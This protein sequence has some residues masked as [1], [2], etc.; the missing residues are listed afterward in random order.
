MHN[1]SELNVGDLLEGLR[2]GRL[3]TVDPDTTLQEA[4][5]IQEAH[6][7]SALIIIE[8][9]KLFGIV[10]ERDLVR[11]AYCKG[12]NPKTAFVKEIMTPGKEVVIVT[13]ETTLK[14]AE[15]LMTKMGFRHLPVMVGEKLDAILSERDLRRAKEIIKA[16]FESRREIQ[17]KVMESTRT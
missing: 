3:I 17:E 14:E 9:K 13:K 16:T 11:K 1:D 4:M 6:D 2:Q 10:T 8:D 12:K 5:V 7:I 15:R